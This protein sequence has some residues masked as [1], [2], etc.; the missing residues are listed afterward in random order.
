[1]R[2]FVYITCMYYFAYI[3]R[4]MLTGL[5]CS[6]VWLCLIMVR[7]QETYAL[8]SLSIQEYTIRN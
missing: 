1:M 2:T 8:K 5:N 7:M 3:T 6:F 4:Q